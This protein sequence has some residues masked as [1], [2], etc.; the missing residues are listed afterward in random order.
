MK[1]KFTRLLSILLAIL[2]LCGTASMI[3]CADENEPPKEGI[4]QTLPE[5]GGEEQKP[6]EVVR[7]PIDY[8]PEET[9]GGTEIHVLEWTVNDMPILRVPWEEIDVDTQTGIMLEDAIFDRNATVE[10]KYDVKITKEYVDI[11]GSPPYNSVFRANEQSGDQR[12]QMITLITARIAPY[13]LENMM[14]NMFELENLHTDMPWWNQDSVRS[15]TVGDALFFAAPEMLLR[16]KGATASVF[17]NKGIA[18]DYEVPDLYEM[19]RQGEWTLDE[20]L[21][22]SEDVTVDL[23]GDDAASSDQDLYGFTGG[24]RDIPYYVFAGMD[25]KFAQIN[26]DGYLEMLFGTDESYVLAWQDILDLVMFSDCYYG[27]AADPKLIPNG[28]E[29]FESDKALFAM[30]LVRRVVIMRNMETD[31]GILPMPKYD[32]AQEDYASL[33]WMHHDSVLGIPG[34]VTNTDAV[35]TVLEYMS[36]LS[37][38]DIYP[39]F[40]E[41]VL[42]DRSMRDEQSVDMLEIIFRTRTF[43]PGHYWLEYELHN[44]NSFLTVFEDKTSN[45]ASLWAKLRG[46]AENKVEEFNETVDDLMY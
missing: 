11:N 43:D 19:V 14:V 40:Y 24:F 42:S 30:D 27:N 21:M 15:Y 45:I 23:D 29:P 35:S 39:I 13:C 5:E 1:T 18:T 22:I 33:V 6:E 17:F 3:A 20:M 37:Y 26:D 7:L 8:L 36:Y 31:Y 10:E 46:P 9:Y 28:F 4:D 12:F 25:K 41:T 44:A 16:D 34:S 32:E 38:Y 2:L